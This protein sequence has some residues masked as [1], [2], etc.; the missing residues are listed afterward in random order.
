MTPKAIKT[1]A[2]LTKALAHVNTLMDAA[3]GSKTEAE[4]EVWSI[5]IEKFEEEHF[6]MEASDPI[7]AIEFRMDQM[8]LSRSDL[9]R[10]IPSKSKVSEVLS[11]RRPLSLP[12]IRALCEGLNIP[13]EILLQKSRLRFAPHKNSRSKRR[14]LHV[15]SH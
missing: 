13:A 3:P 11:R 1:E 14:G 12:M 8:G 5:L 4:L 6:P 2:E 9:L 10:Y 15:A 7:S